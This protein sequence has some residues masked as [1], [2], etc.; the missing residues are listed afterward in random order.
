[1]YFTYGPIEIYKLNLSQS[2]ANDNAMMNSTLSKNGA[3][4]N[5]P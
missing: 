5:Q 4:G 1:M 2:V 3:A